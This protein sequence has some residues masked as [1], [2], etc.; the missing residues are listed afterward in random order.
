[1]GT[2]SRFV[3]PASIRLPSQPWEPGGS[4]GAA[5]PGLVTPASLA[6]D[7]KLEVVHSDF[8]SVR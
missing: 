5:K 1:M 4:R 6:T 7:E 3:L 2:S 8:P